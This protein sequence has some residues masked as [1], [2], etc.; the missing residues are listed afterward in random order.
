MAQAAGDVTANKV[1]QR[2]SA[3]RSMVLPTPKRHQLRW[4]NSVKGA[5]YIKL[6]PVFKHVVTGSRQFMG[7]GFHCDDL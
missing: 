2:S 5:F 7:H 6:Y 3:I 1:K 4:V